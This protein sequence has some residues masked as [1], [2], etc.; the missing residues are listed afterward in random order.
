MASN[1]RSL[2]DEAQTESLPKRI[3]KE[4]L[5]EEEEVQTSSG[6]SSPAS[7]PYESCNGDDDESSSEEDDED[8]K[9][10]DAIYED[11]LKKPF[12]STFA[13]IAPK[14]LLNNIVTKFI[15]NDPDLKSLVS[16]ANSITKRIEPKHADVFQKGIRTKLIG[17][18][19]RDCDVMRKTIEKI[20]FEGILGED[21][22]D[23]RNKYIEELKTNRV[24]VQNV[25]R[26]LEHVACQVASV[27]KNIKEIS[28]ND[29]KVGLSL[30]IIEFF[31]AK[32]LHMVPRWLLRVLRN[33]DTG[34][35]VE[36]VI[37]N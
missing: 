18:I 16:N 19:E 6:S 7:T 23:N 13:E 24:L 35:C 2:P 5:D 32:V 17:N 20:Y 28:S 9:E 12:S 14:D 3:K 30:R 26:L 8:E 34:K 36:R 15:E 37:N 31:Q 25:N 29:V 33:V 1:K 21:E 27:L 22:K 11:M 4:P 10:V